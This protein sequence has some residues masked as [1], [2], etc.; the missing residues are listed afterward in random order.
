MSSQDLSQAKKKNRGKNKKKGGK[1][2]KKAEEF[3]PSSTPPIEAA[4][5]AAAVEE[6]THAA[7]EAPALQTAPSPVEGSTPGLDTAP[8]PAITSEIKLPSPA[9]STTSPSKAEAKTES[10]SPS[11][12][13]S[14]AESKDN[15][16]K[17]EQ[18]TEKVVIHEHHSPKREP[19]PA[20]AKAEEKNPQEPAA[21]KAEE[22]NPQE[23]VSVM[24]LFDAMDEVPKR[25]SNSAFKSFWGVRGASGF[26]SG[27]TAMQVATKFKPTLQG[28][29]V[30]ITGSTIGGLGFESARAMLFAG[31]V[32]VILGRGQEK[33]DL[34]LSSL[35]KDFPEGKLG[36]VVC[37]LASLASVKKAAEE[38]K[39]LALVQG[40]D[41]K[42]RLHLLLNNAGIMAVPYQ[43][44]KDGYEMQFA[45]C[46]LGHFLLTELLL[47]VMKQTMAAEPESFGR[48]VNVSSAAHCCL[49]GLEKDTLYDQKA[50]NDES[51]YH[52]G[53]AYGRAKLANV[54]HAQFLAQ[55]LKEEAT[56]EEKGP[57]A[58]ITALSLMP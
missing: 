7:T 2:T 16:D 50:M 55:R 12:S 17:A 6:V 10:K 28:K 44:S 3:V 24:S 1:F 41:G 13:P 45:A 38:Y 37:D 19:A 23:P 18:E 52:P 31:A 29:V 54:H 43:L 14:K 5:L 25:A 40:S 30:L 35:R 57:E 39:Q 11:K 53:R 48:I 46:H 51:K 33:L 47:P 9:K 36:H 58:R 27:S 32:V 26:G 21:A 20:A 56:K 8:T 15:G 22:K 49:K 34:A 4:P 42:P